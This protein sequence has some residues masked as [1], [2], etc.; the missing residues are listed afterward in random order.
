MIYFA[1]NFLNSEYYRLESARLQKTPFSPVEVGDKVFHVQFPSDAFQK[2]VAQQIENR[3]GGKIKDIL[4]FFRVSDEERDTDWRI[5]SDLNINGQKP[6][7]AIVLFMSPDDGGEL[8]GTALWEHTEYGHSLPEDTTDEEYDRVLLGDANDI[9]M[10]KLN[11]VIGHREN[12]CIS[13]PSA[14]FHSKYPRISQATGGR[15][16]FVMFYSHV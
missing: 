14:Y 3:E 16:I 12:R 8:T 11:S 7:R 13:Y 4:S 10:W 2:N 15:M 5:H 6:E 9:E 1:D